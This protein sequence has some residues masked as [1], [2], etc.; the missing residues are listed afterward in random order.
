M[1]TKSQSPNSRH[2]PPNSGESPNPNF[3]KRI[4][5]YGLRITVYCLLITISLFLSACLASGV[6]DVSNPNGRAAIINNTDLYVVSKDSQKIDFYGFRPDIRF[7]PI[8]APD[9]SAI[10][11]VDLGH[12]LLRQPLDG[13]PSQ[14]LLNRVGSP[15][16]G[17]ITFLPDGQLFIFDTGLNDDRYVRVLNVSTGQTS[18]HLTG[19]NQIFISANAL[20]PKTPPLGVDQASTARLETSRLDSFQVVFLPTV[21][22]IP[23]KTCFY[24]YTADAGGFKAQ[25]QMARVYDADTQLLFVRRVD[26][27]ITSGLL[28]PDGRYVILRVRS[29]GAGGAAQSLYLI[30]LTTNDPPIPLVENAPGRP[31]YVVSPDGTVIAY[32]ATI[33]NVSHLRLY[34]LA[35][36]DRTDLGP[37]TLDPQWWE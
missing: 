5:D 16:P 19:I 1:K 32:E 8:F 2:S 20:R 12:R 35:T 36:G 10:F 7:Q 22:L 23:E 27:D 4:T 14:I 26:N 25:G 3:Q 15:G 18:T 17:A 37:G 31:K 9:G 30:D 11:Y 6:T 28:T 33:N 34:Y 29:L 24:A 21:C 13:S